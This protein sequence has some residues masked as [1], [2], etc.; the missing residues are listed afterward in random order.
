MFEV[1]SG[2]GTHSVHVCDVFKKHTNFN[3]VR[4]GL[5]AGGEGST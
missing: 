2:E 3:M 4:C 1:F 5:R